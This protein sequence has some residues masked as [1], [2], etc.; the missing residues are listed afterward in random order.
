MK[1]FKILLFLFSISFFTQA[2]NLIPNP[3][4]ELHDIPQKLLN[5]RYSFALN[6]IETSEP[7]I[8]YWKSYKAQ[9]GNVQIRNNH[10]VLHLLKSGRRFTRHALTTINTPA[11]DGYF[12]AMLSTENY[13]LVTPLTENLKKGRI[14]RIS[15]YL[16]RPQRY[17][18]R[19]SF[20][21]DFFLAPTLDSF[22]DTLY[23]EQY[24]MDDRIPSEEIP[25]HTIPLPTINDSI[26]MGDPRP[27]HW[28]RFTIDFIA[29]DTFSCLGIGH[30]Y[31]MGSWGST[32][33]VNIDNIQLHCIDC[34]ERHPITDND[35]TMRPDLTLLAKQM[36]F[37]TGSARLTMKAIKALEEVL[38][39]LKDVMNVTTLLQ[40][41]GHTDNVGEYQDNLELS[42][43]RAAAIKAFL[44]DRGIPEEQILTKGYGD[45]KPI[46]DNSTKEGRAQNR[47]VTISLSDPR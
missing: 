1:I 16:R 39:D 35:S 21:S 43:A 25:R 40:I 22:S 19:D 46:S 11:Q 29:E 41:E 2:Q 32:Q 31:T 12:M 28:K 47:R 4:F 27:E 23:N 8:L 30:G 17:F 5:E 37:E 3:S 6:T 45:T 34:D 18:D 38:P 44:V 15:F 42:E 9:D 7:S 33:R 26:S 36:Q 20:D 24:I 14:Y 13:A 10:Q